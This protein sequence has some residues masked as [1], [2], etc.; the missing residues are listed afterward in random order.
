MGNLQ[1]EANRRN[2]K[3]STG[4]KSVSGKARSSANALRHGL[5]RRETSKGSSIERICLS[6]IAAL[7]IKATADIARQDPS[8][9][10]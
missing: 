1:I 7:G 8:T 3:W 6:I 4:P 5:S 9:S 2:A 10:L